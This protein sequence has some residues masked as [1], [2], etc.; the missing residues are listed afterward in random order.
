M[1]ISNPTVE[2]MG[3]Y[4]NRGSNPENSSSP[5]SGKISFSSRWVIT[6][7]NVCG[8]IPILSI[9]IAAGRAFLWYNIQKENDTTKHFPEVRTVITYL[10]GRALT[11][12]LCIGWMFIPIDLI[13][14]GARTVTMKLNPE[15]TNYLENVNPL[16]V[17]EG[18]VTWIDILNIAGWI[19]L[20]S[21]ATAIS[22][23]A[24]MHLEASREQNLEN[25][26]PKNHKTPPIY[27]YTRASLELLGLGWFFA[28][29]DLINLRIRGISIKQQEA[30]ENKTTLL[31]E[32]STF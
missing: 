14:F 26:N 10:K 2:Y 8:W 9:G 4:P 3:M 28:P 22:R 18:H 11:E 23:I 32:E 12:A 27:T 21:I 24:Y 6:T 19:P 29:I 20:V 16:P 25:R 15:V 1:S 7:L 31:L 5:S 17:Q 13:V 30:E